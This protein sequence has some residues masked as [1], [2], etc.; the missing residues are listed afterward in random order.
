M[1]LLQL[2]FEKVWNKNYLLQR[3]KIKNNLLEI[4]NKFAILILA[5]LSLM[6]PRI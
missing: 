2:F 6:Q 3:N 1:Q 5:P 4:C